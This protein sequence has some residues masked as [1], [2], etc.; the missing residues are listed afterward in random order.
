MYNS[1]W[2]I[3]IL[4]FERNT[5]KRT[6]DIDRLGRSWQKKSR[7]NLQGAMER[8]RRRKVGLA[9]DYFCSSSTLMNFCIDTGALPSRWLLKFG[10]T[11]N[12]WWMSFK[13]ML[14][15]RSKRLKGWNF[16]A[17][18]SWQIPVDCVYYNQNR[19]SWF[20]VL[21]KYGCFPLEVQAFSDTWSVRTWIYAKQ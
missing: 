5:K 6:H 19:V 21:W 1:I 4:Y 2:S 18:S 10:Y 13:R 11:S 3:L 16:V 14:L 8:K 15:A 7:R 9:E 20:L 17:R 12:L